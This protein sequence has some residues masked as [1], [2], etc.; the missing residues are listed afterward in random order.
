MTLPSAVVPQVLCG[1][2]AKEHML[3]H[4]GSSGHL[5]VLSLADLSSWCYGCDAYVD[6]EKTQAAK[7]AAYATKSA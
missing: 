3:K 2:Y 6:D 4:S 7:D 5:V 1:R